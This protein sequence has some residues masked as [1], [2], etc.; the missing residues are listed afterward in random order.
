MK[1]R[2]V[3]DL[4]IEFFS[5]KYILPTEPDESDTVLILAGDICVASKA[6]KYKYFFEDVA[7]RFDTILYVFGN[8]EYYGSS[9]LTARNKL[10]D[11]ISEFDNIII[12][13]NEIYVKDNVVF[14]GAVL[15]TDFDLNELN[16]LNAATNMNDYKLIRHGTIV[17]PYGKKLEPINTLLFHSK[18]KKFIFNTL[19][20]K[21]NDKKYVVISHHLPSILSIDPNFKTNNI[22]SA[23]TSR[24]DDDIITH[25]PDIWI[26]GHGHN[27]NDYILGNTRIISNPMGYNITNELN[28]EYDTYKS[29][30]LV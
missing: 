2:M 30:T 15:W 21:T 11:C 5:N 27:S 8:H 22:I 4:H 25:G 7:N 29:I 1:I 23:Y 28:T 10:N 6:P 20:N 17:N 9:I 18:S 16:M 12:L 24:L 19:A 26:H 14:I 3:S 13:E